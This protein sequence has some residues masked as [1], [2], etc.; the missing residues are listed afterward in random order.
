MQ[1]FKVIWKCK[2]ALGWSSSLI[3]PIRSR[4]R[5]CRLGLRQRFANILFFWWSRLV[6]GIIFIQIIN[7]RCLRTNSQVQIRNMNERAAKRRMD[8]GCCHYG[9]KKGWTGSL[10]RR[11]N[12]QRLLRKKLSNQNEEKTLLPFCLQ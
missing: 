10:W 8:V 3:R 4:G 12:G 11:L 2:R 9:W 5:G 7:H 1:Q 6:W